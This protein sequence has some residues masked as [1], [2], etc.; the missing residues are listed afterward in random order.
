MQVLGSNEQFAATVTD[1]DSRRYQK[2]TLGAR[3]E[4]TLPRGAMFPQCF[5]GNNGD[6]EKPRITPKCAFNVE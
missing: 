3:R 5:N 2:R 6:E 1:N 4:E